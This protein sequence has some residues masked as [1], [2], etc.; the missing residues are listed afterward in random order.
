MRAAGAV[1]IAV[2]NEETSPRAAAGDL[3]IELGA[4]AERA[5]TATKAFT[6]L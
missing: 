6:G 1:T 2:T 5:V 3:S 4:G